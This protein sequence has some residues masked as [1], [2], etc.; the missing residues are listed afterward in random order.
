MERY[1]VIFIKTGIERLD[2][3]T[4]SNPDA[5]SELIRSK[6]GPIHIK[7]IER[8]I[9]NDRGVVTGSRTVYLEPKSQLQPLGVWIAEATTN[10]GYVVLGIA[11]PLVVLVGIIW[12]VKITWTVV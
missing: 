2:I 7:R 6:H 9:I 1:E 10:A 3:V 11:L 8:L 12:L 5:A 4:A